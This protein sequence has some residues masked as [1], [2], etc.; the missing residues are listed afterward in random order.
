M[1]AA[2]AVTAMLKTMS[3]LTT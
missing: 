3:L 2:P 1:T